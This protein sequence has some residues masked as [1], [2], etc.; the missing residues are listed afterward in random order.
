MEARTC[1]ICLENMFCKSL[2]TLG[3]RDCSCLVSMVRWHGSFQAT[4]IQDKVTAAPGFRATSLSPWWIHGSMVRATICCQRK[5]F[6]FLVTLLLCPTEARVPCQELDAEAFLLTQLCF[7]L[8]IG[9]QH[10]PL[11]S[12]GWGQS[13][14]FSAA[15]KMLERDR[16]SGI[17][18]KTVVNHSFER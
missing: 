12:L 3:N 18:L 5:D 2:K 15:T 6:L 10:L 7:Y 8:Q 16:N 1:V 13:I 17:F 14:T 11:V 9:G 4:V